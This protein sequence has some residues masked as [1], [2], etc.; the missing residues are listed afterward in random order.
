MI[1]ASKS[2]VSPN[3]LAD[4]N[5]SA[6][7]SIQIDMD[8]HQKDSTE[9]QLLGNQLVQGQLIENVD[10]IDLAALKINQHLLNCVVKKFIVSHEVDVKNAKDISTLAPSFQAHFITK[11][12]EVLCADHATSL[13]VRQQ[14]FVIAGEQI[15]QINLSAKDL[16]SPAFL[17]KLEASDKMARQLFHEKKT[18]EEERIK[19]IEDDA[20]RR[21][22]KMGL[23]DKNKHF[24]EHY[25]KNRKI[26][27]SSD[28]F[29][30]GAVNI[31]NHLLRLTLDQ[32]KALG[33]QNDALDLIEPIP[34]PKYFPSI[35]QPETHSPKSSFSP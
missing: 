27:A 6:T 20:F 14:A 18:K 32:L 35:T 15:D 16:Q 29:E 13:A 28:D 33:Y 3:L 25:K 10:D 34:T 7:T 8:V 5:G 17:E 12:K 31:F 30:F 1:N 24:Y 19:K 11:I 2:S 21:I 4:Q 26:D 9:N 22:A 23:D